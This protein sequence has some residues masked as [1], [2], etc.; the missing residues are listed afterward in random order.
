M[1]FNSGFREL[2]VFD[3]LAVPFLSCHLQTLLLVDIG[4]LMSLVVKV[5]MFS[6]LCITKAA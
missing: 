4:T 2:T 1:G 6:F 5:P 3:T